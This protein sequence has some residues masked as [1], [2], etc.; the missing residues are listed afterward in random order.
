[1][2]TAGLGEIFSL[3]RT[4]AQSRLCEK[5]YGRA[6]AERSRS[7]QDKHSDEAISDQRSPRSA[8]L[9]RTREDRRSTYLVCLKICAATILLFM[10][11]KNL[12]AE[13][14]F[15]GYFEA[16]GSTMQLGKNNYTYGFNKFRLDVEAR[17]ND[18]VLI[19]A[20]VNIQK[21]WGKTSWNVY[22]FLPGYENS[23]L[24]WIEELKDTVLIDNVYMRIAFPWLDLTVGR[25]QISPGVGYAWNPTDIFNSKSLLDPSYEQTGVSA[26]RFDFPLNDR[27]SFKAII[28]PD[29]KL[30]ESTQQYALKTG[31]GSFDFAATAT[32]QSK[33]DWNST[34]L[35]RSDI[36]DR[37]MFGGSIIGELLA[38]GVW[39]EGAHNILQVE[40]PPWSSY[41]PLDSEETFTE[42][43]VGV[44]H[45]FDNSVYL[46]AEYLHNGLGVAEE[47]DLTLGDYFSALGGETH[48]LMQDYGFL[49][50]MH[51]TFDYVTLSAITFANFNDNSGVFSPILDWSIFEDTNISLQGSYAWGKDDTEFGL[52]DWGLTLNITSNF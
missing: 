2:R 41:M 46:L 4:H 52:Q 47:E 33:Q 42:F 12:F 20:N 23:G 8:L 25:Q 32:F 49:Y 29:A 15:F 44:D 24:V 21:Y 27:S 51:P 48:S 28:L 17:P 31:G 39:V 40:S 38:W 45:T 14:D 30:E 34:L 3:M 37:N 50:I 19:G 1:M 43:V 36:M 7:T 5:P 35:G 22:D 16:E 26:I 18:N 9:R 13:T 6:W 11:P 10:V